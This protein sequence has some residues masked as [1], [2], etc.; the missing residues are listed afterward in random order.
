MLKSYDEMNAEQKMAYRIGRADALSEASPGELL[1]AAR[2]HADYDAA[3]RKWIGSDPPD[4]WPGNWDDLIQAVIEQ[5]V[6]PVVD[7]ALGA[8]DE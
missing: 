6:K 2:P 3:A 5:T 7:A 4:D 8:D 1:E